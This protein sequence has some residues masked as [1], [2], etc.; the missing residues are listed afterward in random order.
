M[1][2]K[3]VNCLKCGVLSSPQ[4]L[5]IKHK[6]VSI[7][8]SLKPTPVLIHISERMHVGLHKKW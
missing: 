3:K 2:K 5:R 7:E 8:K 6:V 1:I 4:M